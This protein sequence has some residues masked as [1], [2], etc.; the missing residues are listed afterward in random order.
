M[1]TCLP[2]SQYRRLYRA[3]DVQ[4]GRVCK[5]SISEN[6][7]RNL[8]TSN[9]TVGLP[10]SLLRRRWSS[11]AGVV[12]GGGRN[13]RNT[14]GAHN[15]CCHRT[16]PPT[17]D[18]DIFWIK[19]AHSYMCDAQRPRGARPFRHTQIRKFTTVSYL[20][21]FARL[22]RRCR[23]TA[24]SPLV[25]VQVMADSRR[26]ARRPQGRPRGRHARLIV[27]PMF[28]ARIS[29]CDGPAAAARLGRSSSAVEP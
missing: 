8:R 27:R 9:Q 15:C 4:D 11:S 26:S 13:T 5:F 17:A 3:V 2:R 12:V 24:R 29:C 1:R 22:P 18:L 14:R 6:W 19:M 16:W 25:R 21:T 7:D 28:Y 10:V 20:R 23:H